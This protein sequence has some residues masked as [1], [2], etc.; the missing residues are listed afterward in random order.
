MKVNKIETEI[1][2]NFQNSK[3]DI[4]TIKIDDDVCIIDKNKVM[5]I[6]KVLFITQ[7]SIHLSIE[8][9]R[10]VGIKFKNIERISLEEY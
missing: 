4:L 8:Y 6:G 10:F 7:D 5:Y 9:T 1:V 3:G 2:A